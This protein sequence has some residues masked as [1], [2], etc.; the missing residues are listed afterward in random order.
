[1]MNVRDRRAA[2]RLSER[3]RARSLAWRLRG[4]DSA[5]WYVEVRRKLGA[6][7]RRFTGDFMGRTKRHDTRAGAMIDG[8]DLVAALMPA[9][10]LPGAPLG[11]RNAANWPAKRAAR[12]AAIRDAIR[13]SRP[14]F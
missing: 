6:H 13:E 10:G 11:N 8:G 3:A 2:N 4:D 5:G 7:K 1:M 12:E 14:A 9:T